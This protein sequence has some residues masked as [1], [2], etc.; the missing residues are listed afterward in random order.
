MAAVTS[1][2]LGWGGLRI[3]TM[4]KQVPKRLSLLRHHGTP[5]MAQTHSCLKHVRRSNHAKISPAA[6]LPT[7]LLSLPRLNTPRG[8]DGR[9]APP[10]LQGSLTR[11]GP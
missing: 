2:C 7:S 8:G 3:E 5:M 9:W 11:I 10:L 1:A 6:L 4:L